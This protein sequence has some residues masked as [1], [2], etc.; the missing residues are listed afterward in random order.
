MPELT[1]SSLVQNEIIKLHE[2]D[3]DT[4]FLVGHQ[5]QFDGI[6]YN[7]LKSFER[8]FPDLQYKIVLAH[9]P[10]QKEDYELY[11]PVRTYYPEGLELVHPNYAITR[12]NRWM[13]D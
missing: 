13:I 7:I 11:P 3:P 9:M 2:E 5:G 10:G 4:E 8:A 6:V 12:R 1:V